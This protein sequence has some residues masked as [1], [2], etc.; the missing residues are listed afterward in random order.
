M[1]MKMRLYPDWGFKVLKSQPP[2]G[3]YETYSKDVGHE[4]IMAARLV[5]IRFNHMDNEGQVSEFTPPKY[6]TSFKLRHYRA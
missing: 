4:L 1:A 2:G 5:F 3:R 6:L